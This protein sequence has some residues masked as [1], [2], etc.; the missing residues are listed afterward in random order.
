LYDDRWSRRLDDLLERLAAR[1]GQRA[2]ENR[3]AQRGRRLA[4]L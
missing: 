4:Q 2:V 1:R 3:E